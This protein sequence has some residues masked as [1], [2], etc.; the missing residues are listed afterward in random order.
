MEQFEKDLKNA[1]F[2]VVHEKFVT[3]FS[4][5][6]VTLFTLQINLTGISP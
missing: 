4:L 6:E 1:A 3:L 5:F 2:F